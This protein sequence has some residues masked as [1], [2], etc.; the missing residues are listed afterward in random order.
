MKTHSAVGLAVA[1]TLLPE[2][3]RSGFNRFAGEGAGA[4]V[5]QVR[6]PVYGL[7]LVVLMLARPQGLF[8]TRELWDRR[9]GQGATP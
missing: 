2:A 8:G 4:V 5:D 6:M 3:L 1:L 7:L 9:K